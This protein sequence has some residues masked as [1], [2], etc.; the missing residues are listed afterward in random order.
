MIGFANVSSAWK[1]R[2][3]FNRCYI[4][5]M[6]GGGIYVK[7]K[8]F[9]STFENLECDHRQLL[10]SGAAM[11]T[12]NIRDPPSSVALAAAWSTGSTGSEKGKICS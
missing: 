8:R 12:L 10:A 5:Q 3:T 11:K 7:E 2:D 9:K 6:L 1:G 4:L